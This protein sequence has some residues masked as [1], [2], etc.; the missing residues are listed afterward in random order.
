VTDKLTL[1]GSLRYAHEKKTVDFPAVGLADAIS[2]KTKVHKWIPAATLSYKVSGGVVYARY[3]KGF[4]T[5]GPNPLVRP[6][7]L[8]A[9]QQ[10]G[11][12][13]KPETVD[14]YEIGYRA[15]LFDRKV[16]FTSAI[17]YNKYKGIHTTT[18]GTTGNTDISNALINLG[19]ARTYG[20]EASVT[21]RVSQ[22]L[23]LSANIGYL[24][25]KY[26]KA[27]FTGNDLLLARFAS[28]N[29][30]ILAPKWQGGFQVNYDQP[31]NDSMNVKGNLL[32]SY[33]SSHN[34]GALEDPLI[35]QKGYSLVNLRAGMT[36]MHD[37]L[38]LYLFANNLFDKRYYV[39]G[40]T[41]GVGS[42]N[43]PANPR[44]I[45]GTV[46]VKF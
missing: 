30:M 3:A 41:S 7:R 18:S 26:Q 24:N 11:L 40:S 12:I 27:E 13:L 35:R 45:G 46:E 29:R 21:W 17:F 16:Q 43:T 38:G 34:F 44:L 15:T 23:T 4:K 42:Y 36:F 5:G 6:D 28:G 25:A 14:T 8:P 10:T 33:I 22:P 2:D 32:Y 20:A 37:R 19:N 1:Q 31:I 39:F 9:D